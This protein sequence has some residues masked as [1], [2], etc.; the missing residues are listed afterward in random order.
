M[1]AAGLTGLREASL[2]KIDCDLRWGRRNH[3]R[4]VWPVR[5]MVGVEYNDIPEKR[6]ALEAYLKELQADYKKR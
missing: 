4:R 3:H 1:D 2:V 5:N 6:Q